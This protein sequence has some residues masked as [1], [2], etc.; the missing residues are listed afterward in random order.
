MI[1]KNHSEFSTVDDVKR[2]ALIW[3]M[4]SKSSRNA[5]FVSYKITLPRL[6]I[7]GTLSMRRYYDPV[8][9]GIIH[10]PAV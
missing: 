3:K 10:D 2:V 7:I 4:K 8:Y 9:T 1:R 5:N 6:A